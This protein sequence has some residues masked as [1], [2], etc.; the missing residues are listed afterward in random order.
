MRKTL[1]TFFALTLLASPIFAQESPGLFDRF[2]GDSESDDATEDPGGFLERLIEDNLSGEGRDVEITSFEGALGGRATMETFTISDADGVWLSLS[3]V[4]LDWNRSA[5]LRGRL[6]VAELS[7]ETIALTRLPAPGEDTAPAP[8][9]SGF[10]LPELPVSV[11]I[12]GL[13]AE[14]VEIGAPVFGIETIASLQGGFRLEG[15]EGSAQLDV[16]RLNGEGQLVLDAS[17]SNETENLAIDLSLSEAADGIVANLINL[18]GKPPLDFSIQGAA[19]LS[20]FAADIQLATDGEDR[21]TGRI[22]TAAPQDNNA[23]ARIINADLRGDI[24]PLFDVAYQPFFGPDTT[25]TAAVTTFA[26]GRTDISNLAISAESLSLDGQ[27]S[28]AAGGLPR[29]IAI[30][31]AIANPE[32]G[33]V[34]LP[35]SGPETRVE[36]IDLDVSFDA[37][38]GD[39][40]TGS[41]EIADLNRPGFSAQSLSLDGSGQINST[42][43][44]SVSANLRFAATAL[45][46]GNPNAEQALGEEVTGRLDIDWTSGGP[47]ELSDL[48]IDGE[49]Y[50]LNGDA[51]VTFTDNG[52]EI[53]GALD[54]RAT[55]LAAFS[56]IAQR[57]LGGAAELA[58]KFRV[59]PLAG[60]FEVDAEGATRDLIV[61]QP[62][63]DSILEG[64]VDLALSARRN[65]N[66]TF[67][68]IE[69]LSSPNAEITGSAA[70]RTGA[71]EIELNA[72]LADAALVLP[73]VEGPVRVAANA[74]EVDGRWEWTLDSAFERTVLTATG[75]AV[76][77]FETPVIAA[78]GRL[79]ADALADFAQLAGRPL[80]GS[81]D[82]TFSTEIVT[83]LSRV[84]LNLDGTASDL[85]IG[86]D[87]ADALL[88]G[89]LALLVDIALA[90]QVVTV[91]QSSINGSAASI[92]VDGTL[93]ATSGT[94]ALSG[95]IPDVATIL[96]NAPPGAL[97]FDAETSRDGDIWGFDVTAVGPAV[98]LASKGTVSNPT[99][100]VPEVQGTVN[101]SLSDLSL[102]SELANRNLAGSLD[103]NAGGRAN[104]D[105]SDFDIDATVTGS[106]V[107]T[108]IAEVDTALAGALSSEIIAAR[109]GDAIRIET[110]QLSSDLVSINAE[111]ALGPVGSAITL[112]ARLANVAP[113]VPG[114]SGAATVNGTVT[115][116]TDDRLALDLNATGPGGARA[117]ILGDTAIDG[118]NLSLGING[119]APLGLLNRFLEPRSLAGDVGFDLRLDGRPALESLSG[120]ITSANARL[121]APALGVTL[122]NTNLNMSLANAN[123]TISAATTVSTGGRIGIEGQIA[124]TGQRSADLDIRLVDVV[125]TDPQLY[126][127]E[128]SGSVTVDGPLA[129]GARIAGDLSLGETN[130]RIPSSGFGGAGAI[131]EIIHINEPPPVRRTR[132]RAGILQRNDE[133]TATTG[134]VFP[135][136]IS[137]DAPNRIFIRG[138]G[139]DSEF[140]G[141][142]R[143]TGTTA[144]VIPQGAFNLIRGRLDI[145]G[146]RL[147]LEEA[148]VTIQGSFIPV[149]RIRATTDAEDVSVAVIVAGP[150]NNPEITFTSDPELPQEEVLARLLFGRELES[151]SPIQAG[152]LALA[153]RTLAGQ[154]GEGIISNVRDGVGLADFDVTSDEDGNAAV[155]AGAYLGENIYTDVTVTATGETELNL[156]LDLSRSVTLKGSTATDG[157][158]SV[159]VFFERDY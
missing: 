118:S 42:T 10:Q 90:D 127:T 125:L 108:G 28:L 98:S 132:D 51:D 34:L 29:E 106:N 38:E 49:S 158:T 114:F 144:N 137:I 135:L 155:R 47:L 32:G 159:G 112:D 109:D 65:T 95:R 113:F 110:A 14:R 87:Q 70:L 33:A 20:D 17:Y 153:V 86:Q 99:A 122:D 43:P 27:I 41:F 6:E 93:S 149:L 16:A 2:F 116:A 124:L 74:A 102:F 63:A 36:R 100:P 9:A 1:V 54:V 120:R 8:E 75:T 7:A 83:D 151:L 13:S 143:I 121:V 60:F 81:I 94:L 84:T 22:T 134:P 138:R 30:T 103:I 104:A 105:F 19:P 146:Q 88:T 142:L 37:A 128:I 101:G 50:G 150:A 44:Q 68:S 55:R 77:V 40:W 26:D 97:S 82:T 91:R 18:P 117:T 48:A 62:Q 73:Q 59:E 145:L 46:L 79:A 11:A 76:D 133:T 154:G 156:N 35:L 4:V 15:G 53:T 45:D 64:E 52:P 5:L 78:N 58:T 89:E 71:S 115:Q 66:G 96:A 57:R 92:E 152:R 139:L 21:L 72:R 56:G 107:R 85:K 129:G 111:G 69:R 23:V 25:L 12:E 123:A 131:P 67:L 140:G 130:I 136:D 24:A 147:A 61:S 141:A 119:G 126:E 31:G 3:N 80:S 157:D 148:T 39:L